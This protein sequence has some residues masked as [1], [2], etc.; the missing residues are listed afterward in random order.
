MTPRSMTGIFHDLASNRHEARNAM[1][2]FVVVS[3]KRNGQ[4]YKVTARD[5]AT[6]GTVTR[7]DAEVRQAALEAMNPGRMFTILAL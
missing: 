5:I 3:V 4:P 6:C 2:R 7:A 1:K